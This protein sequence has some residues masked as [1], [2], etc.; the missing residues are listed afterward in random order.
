MQQRHIERM[1]EVF[2]EMPDR[3]FSP[4]EVFF[5]FKN[6]RLRIS[7]FGGVFSLENWETEAEYAYSNNFNTFIKKL[8]KA[9]KLLD[10]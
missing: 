8:E 9:R 4:K 1:K 6:K 3:F 10:E 7:H 5:N 2:P